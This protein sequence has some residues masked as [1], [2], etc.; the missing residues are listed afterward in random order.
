MRQ[1]APTAH[2]V[3]RIGTSRGSLAPPD[4]DSRTCEIRTQT[5]TR[6]A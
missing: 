5:D 3:A 1:G 2:D 4:P 6:L